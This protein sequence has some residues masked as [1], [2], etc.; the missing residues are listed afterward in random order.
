MKVKREKSVDSVIFQDE[1]INNYGIL[2]KRSRRELSIDM[3]TERSFKNNQT[4]FT[5]LTSIL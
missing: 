3:V 2:I 5:C 1:L 4:L